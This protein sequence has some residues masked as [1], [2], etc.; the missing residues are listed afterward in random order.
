MVLDDLKEELCRYFS[1]QEISVKTG[2][3]NPFLNAAIKDVNLATK[4]KGI[5]Q[6]MRC[7]TWNSF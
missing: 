7:Y 4:A 1:V 3:L 6:P 5:Y 2:I